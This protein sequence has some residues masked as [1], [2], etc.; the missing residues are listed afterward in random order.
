ME[1]VKTPHTERGTTNQSHC[2]CSPGKVFV[3]M[4][5]G[6]R[7]PHLNRHHHAQQSGFTVGSQQQMLSFPSGS[8]V[9]RINH[10]P[11]M[12][13]ID[14]K[15]ALDSADRSALWHSR[16]SAKSVHGLH[17]GTG[18]R[19]CIGS[20]LLPCFCTISGEQLGCIL[21]PAPFC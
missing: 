5:V 4:L 2:Y 7:R 16:C 13:H 19:V 18:A 17:A 14:I 11:H 3:H 6:R 15:A 1:L 21:A 10:P 8:A 12:T 20:W 9:P